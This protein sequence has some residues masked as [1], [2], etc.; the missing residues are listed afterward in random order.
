MALLLCVLA[1]HRVLAV[2]NGQIVDMN[3]PMVAC[4][5]SSHR[6]SVGRNAPPG[7]ATPWDSPAISLHPKKVVLQAED[8]GIVRVA[9]ASG[10]FGYRIQHRLNLAWRFRDD[11]QHIG[12]GSLLLHSLSQA[13]PRVVDLPSVFV[14]L[15]FEVGGGVASTT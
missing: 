9:Q 12:G 6:V 5:S 7:V 11:A 13:F 8:S 1:P 4:G 14:E 2:L 15:L 3:R 10:I